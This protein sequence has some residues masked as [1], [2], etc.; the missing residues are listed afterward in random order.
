MEGILAL[1]RERRR[2]AGEGFRQKDIA[3]RALVLVV[4]ADAVLSYASFL[5]HHC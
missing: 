5:Y 3:E 4:V 2:R 1:H